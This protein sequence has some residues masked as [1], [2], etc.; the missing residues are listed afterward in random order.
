MYFTREALEQ[1]SGDFPATHR[2][3]RLASFGV[4]ADLCCGIG[5]DALAFARTG[6]TVHAV[7]RD[8]LRLAMTNANAA[9]LGLNEQI[10][11]H[12]SDALSTPLPVVAAAFADPDR[13]VQGRRH[14]DPEQYMPSLSAIRARFPADFP[15]AVKLAPGVAWRHV[16]ELGAEVEFVSL[17]G[18]LKECVVW[19]GP[20]RSTARRAT[21][22]PGGITLQGQTRTSQ[23]DLSPMQD[24]L[25]D[26]DPAIVR[27]GLTAELAAELDVAPLDHTIALF[28]GPHAIESPM[29]SSFRVESAT[30]F[31]LPRLRDH[32]RANRVGRVTFIKRGSLIDADETMRKLKLEGDDHRTVVLTRLAGEEIMIIATRD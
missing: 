25:F 30:R 27:A 13:R 6:L 29:V 16:E 4:V 15:L 1:S 11:G 14:L 20:L 18:E 19:F 9:A 26:P 28:T 7:E 3:R 32:L 21:L 5:G 23:P 2:A 8:P 22:L 12:E 31:H 10:H 24:Y 17:R